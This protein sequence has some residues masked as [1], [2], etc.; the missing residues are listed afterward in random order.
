M[1]WTPAAIVT[2]RAH[3]AAGRSYEATRKR[4]AC[5]RAAVAGAVR[6]YIQQVQDPRSSEQR[7]RYNAKRKL[8][9]GLTTKR[10]AA[11]LRWTEETLTEPY[12]LRKL[13]R[14]VERKLSS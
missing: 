7:N 10:K 12:A 13:R 9:E 3:L 11:P 6:R 8:V 14:Q 5:S 2:L 4:M 1:I